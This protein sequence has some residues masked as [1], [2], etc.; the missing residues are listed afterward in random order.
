M[1]ALLLDISLASGHP[2][3]PWLRYEEA[4]ELFGGQARDSATRLARRT[5]MLLTLL[6]LATAALTATVLEI[7]GVAVDMFVSAAL[8]V[9]FAFVA[10]A[11]GVWHR[12]NKSATSQ[13]IGGFAVIAVGCWPSTPSTKH[14]ATRS[15]LTQRA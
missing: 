15:S 1:E 13:A 14:S 11:A 8:A 4:Q 5:A 12:D 6:G 9:G 7:A 2:E 10:A 3:Q